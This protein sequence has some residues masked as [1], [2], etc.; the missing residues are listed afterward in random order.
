MRRGRDEF[1]FGTAFPF[2]ACTRAGLCRPCFSST[3]LR[4]WAPPR[5]AVVGDEVA[6]VLHG[7]RPVIHEVLI[8]VVGIE[9]RRCSEGGEQILGDGFDER[10][11]M[12]VL[13]EVLEQRGAGLLP[14]GE[15]LGHRAR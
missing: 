13:G 9:Q 12:A 10:L 7:L 15:E 11:G 1:G 6:I 5:P 3:K 4:G 14:L 8:H 2:C